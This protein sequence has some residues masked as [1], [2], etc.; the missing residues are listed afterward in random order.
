V[1]NIFYHTIYV[2][3]DRLI[4]SLEN[5]IKNC[6]Q[7]FSDDFYIYLSPTKFSSE[8]LLIAVFWNLLEARCIGFSTEKMPLNST[9]LF[10]DDFLITGSNLFGS[11]ES[12]TYDQGRTD[13]KFVA[14]VAGSTSSAISQAVEFPVRIFSHF[15]INSV[16]FPSKFDADLYYGGYRPGDDVSDQNEDSKAIALYADHKISNIMG[17]FPYLYH[18][19]RVDGIE[20]GC[21]ITHPPDEPLKQRVWE[22]FFRNLLSPPTLFKYDV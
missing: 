9:I 8:T 11:I 4:Q 13:L 1:K 5:S 2:P 17:N 6:L 15:R 20:V 22:S 18:Y 21:I 12:L 14:C 19:G 16:P 7:T 10:I 3:W